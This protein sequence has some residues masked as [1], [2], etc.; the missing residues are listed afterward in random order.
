MRHSITTISQLQVSI[1]AAA[2]FEAG[3]QLNKSHGPAE[4]AAQALFAWNL[5]DDERGRAYN[6]AVMAIAAE[7]KLATHQSQ[8]AAK[9]FN[10]KPQTWSQTSKAG[11]AA[12]VALA[13]ATAPLKFITLEA[14]QKYAARI[15]APRVERTASKKDVATSLASKYLKLSAAQKRWFLDAIKAGE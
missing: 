14:A 6:V 11:V 7:Y 12:S 2:K 8:R 15:T 9:G 1:F 13:K 3:V 10:F 4:R 5:P